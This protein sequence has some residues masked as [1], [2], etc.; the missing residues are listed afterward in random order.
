M[1]NNKKAM[2]QL[3]DNILQSGISHSTIFC[4]ELD[5]PNFSCRKQH[6]AVHWNTERKLVW[7]LDGGP[8]KGHKEEKHLG[9]YFSQRLGYSLEYI[10]IKADDYLVYGGECGCQGQ[11]Q[12]S[13]ALTFEQIQGQLIKPFEHISLNQS[14]RP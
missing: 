9:K 11:A 8:L 4:D 1:I 12:R 7:I 14:L 13:A 2:R 5:D 10:R 6:Y 3:A